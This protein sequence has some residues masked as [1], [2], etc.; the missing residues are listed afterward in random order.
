MASSRRAAPHTAATRPKMRDSGPV[1][2]TLPC[3]A[4]LPGLRRR[5]CL[6]ELSTT[7]PS[8]GPRKIAWLQ[9]KK[10]AAAIPPKVKASGSRPVCQS[11]TIRPM[12]NHPRTVSERA[13]IAEMAHSSVVKG[14]SG[15]TLDNKRVKP[16]TAIANQIPVA[17]ST[18]GYWIETVFRQPAQR[19]LSSSQLR[20]GMFSNQRSWRPQF[21][22][23]DRGDRMLSPRGRRT[24]HTFRKLPKIRP[25]RNAAASK[26]TAEKITSS[27]CLY[28]LLRASALL[29]SPSDLI[30]SSV[31]SLPADDSM[32]V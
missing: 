12:S 17:S 11:I 16:E 14:A 25:S 19:A 27:V 2:K 23:C 22:Q 13:A 15:G 9:M 6:L 1:R 29:Q 5:S 3:A 18:A 21:R 30:E 4:K 31:A 26:K 7:C 28:E 20:R 24:I 8:P 10:N 32:A